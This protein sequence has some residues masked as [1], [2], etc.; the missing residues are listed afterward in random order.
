M[1]I[2]GVKKGVANGLKAAG[3]RLEVLVCVA[4]PHAWILTFLRFI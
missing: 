4:C 1:S 3:I 2:Q